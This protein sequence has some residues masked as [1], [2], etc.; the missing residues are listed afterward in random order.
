[1][2]PSMRQ[3]LF[4]AILIT[5]CVAGTRYAAITPPWQA[6]DEPAHYNYIRYLAQQPDFPELTARCYDQ[7]YLNQLRFH[8]FPPELSVANICYE[9]HQPPLYYILSEPF[10]VLGDGLLLAARLVS[11]LLGAGVVT[12]TYFISSTIFPEQPTI[13]L[14]A[15][16]FVAFVPMHVAILASVNN[17][18]LA[19]LIFA[20]ILLVLVRRLRRTDAPTLGQNAA[21]G[22]LLGLALITKMTIYIAVPLTALVLLI[23]AVQNGFTWQN[24]V[25]PA[26]AV[27]GIALLIALPWYIRNAMLYSN[28][29]ILG[30]GR[31]DDVV[32]GQ[33]R[34]GEFISEVGLV[35]YA[36]TFATTTFH[37]FWGQFGWMAV[38]MDGRT[39]RLL[40]LL[41]FLAL[42]GLLL[43]TVDQL[44]Q[45]STVSL[46][47]RQW[48]MLAVLALSIVFTGLAY[49]WY[50]LS[51]VQ[52]QGRYL[53]SSIIPLGIFFALGLHSVLEIRRRWV[54]ITLLGL[55]TLWLG[56][57]SFLQGGLDK[58]GVLIGSVLLVLATGRSFWPRYQ[59]IFSASLA[60]TWY[61]GLALLTLLSP[62]WF[63]VPNL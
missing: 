35:A 47:R 54:L 3:L 21:L 41:S 11:V 7:T 23:S 50:N 57:A 48:A 45:R 63:I 12:I 8:K 27:F 49:G 14:G 51:F 32:V 6:P 53:F 31:H 18:A 34:T 9:F 36:Q 62:H 25:L 20:A 10:F 13:S 39:Y 52:F 33:L 56:A 19:E 26:A 44:Q 60:A 5:Y 46:L 4:F 1:M 28:L 16:A 43:F 40:A 38:P 61:G 37:S 24:L 17:D 22:I 30:L 29:D 55:S 59:A 42:S 15:M 2:V 58:W